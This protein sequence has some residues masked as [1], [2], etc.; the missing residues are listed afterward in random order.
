MVIQVDRF[1][2]IKDENFQYP[3]IA[4]CSEIPD[5]SNCEFELRDGIYCDFMLCVGGGRMVSQELKDLLCTY[6]YDESNVVF[7]PLMINSEEFGPRQYYFLHFKAVEDCIDYDNSKKIDGRVI[8]PALD[9]YKL[10]GH[11]FFVINKFTTSMVVSNKIM[12]EM[13]KRKMKEGI[14]FSP[15]YCLNK[16]EVQ[17]K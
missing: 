12:N 17:K 14:I 16:P 8:V 3:L 6:S 11:D 4:D 7:I 13:K 10:S 15:V 9:F 2:L 5:L 1:F